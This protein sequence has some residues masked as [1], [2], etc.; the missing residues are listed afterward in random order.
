MSGL[1][2]ADSV[3]SKVAISGRVSCRSLQLPRGEGDRTQGVGS[4]LYKITIPDR[5]QKM[6]R[7]SNAFDRS[8][9][10]SLATWTD[11]SPLVDLQVQ[12]F[13]RTLLSLLFLPSMSVP[14]GVI[15]VPMGKVGR[16]SLN[17]R[18]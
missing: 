18:S 16:N 12:T 9:S 13:P 1:V 2:W 3:A 4:L 17:T 5:R 8:T 10:V 14:I 6:P 11:F 7:S 15:I